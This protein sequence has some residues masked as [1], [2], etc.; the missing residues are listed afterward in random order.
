MLKLSFCWRYIHGISWSWFNNLHR[1]LSPNSHFCSPDGLDMSSK[2]LRCRPRHQMNLPHLSWWSGHE[3]NMAEHCPSFKI[4]V[5][6]LLIIA[7]WIQNT[8]LPFV[9]FCLAASSVLLFLFPTLLSKNDLWQTYRYIQIFPAEVWNLLRFNSYWVSWE[10][11]HILITY[12]RATKSFRKAG[13][14]RMAI[15]ITIC[16][17]WFWWFRS[18]GILELDTCENWCFFLKESRPMTQSL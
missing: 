6:W 11:Y 8:I 3:T 10:H 1:I 17:R 2:P 7:I 15:Y 9:S 13:W 12:D 14:E 4:S 18:C 16:T 5:G